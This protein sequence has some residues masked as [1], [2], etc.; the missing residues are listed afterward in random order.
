MASASANDDRAA[1]FTEAIV[2]LQQA[3]QSFQTDIETGRPEV[4]LTPM[5][6]EL[7]DDSAPVALRLTSVSNE[8]QSQLKKLEEHLSTLENQLRSRGQWH[9][10][11]RQSATSTPT[12]LEISDLST[13]INLLA[14][15]ITSTYPSCHM[16]PQS[17]FSTYSW[18]WDPAWH[19]FYTYLP[20]QNTYV[21]LSQWKLNEVRGV[22]EYVSMA[23]A[24]LMPDTA[25]EMLGAWE[26]WMWD[27]SLKEWRLEV[28]TE[29]GDGESCICASRW[30][31]Q[32]NGEW[33]YVGILGNVG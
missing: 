2:S 31:V 18:S 8:V 30:Q 19:E 11:T 16:T 17:L 26:D 23:D 21:Y 9:A 4:F 15:I 12:I 10:P 25:A 32:N 1:H 33:V 29:G 6:L 27:P 14:H 22:W 13:A 3:I 20:R 7:R 5:S 24:N 28:K